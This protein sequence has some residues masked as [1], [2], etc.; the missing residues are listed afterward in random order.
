[1]VMAFAIA[2]PLSILALTGTWRGELSL[3][4]NKL[5]LVFH[6]SEEA[7]GQSR[8][9]IDSPMQ[10]ATGIP[11]TVNYCDADSVSL[12]VK[13]IG[14]SFAAKILGSEIKGTFSQRGYSFPLT[15]TPEQ[16]IYERRPQTPRPP[17]PYTTTDTTFVSTDGTVLSGTI[18][19]PEERE[20]FTPAVVLVTG[21][22]PQN[23]DE[24]LFE[25]RPFA[26]IAD[27]LA[28]N[29]IASLR[30][31]DRGV[32]ESKGDFAK[33]GLDTFEADAEAA[34]NFLRGM[35]GKGKTGIIGHSEG[36]TIALKLA[37]EGK[38]DFAVSLAGAFAKG[39]DLILAQNIRAIEKLNVSPKQKEDVTTLISEVFDDIIEGKN[40]SE[41]KIDD[42]ITAGN[43]DIPPLFLTSL[44]R[45]LN[46]TQGTYF[47][48]LVSLDPS[49]WLGAVTVPVLA[50][51]GMCDT[52][53]DCAANLGA[54]KRYLP[55][56]ETKQYDGLNHL[57]QHA[58][59][60][61]VSEYAGI[62]ETI[63]AEVLN[64]I[65]AFIKSTSQLPAN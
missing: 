62:K 26:V 17:Y 24:E 39:K 46:A 3:G 32:G 40:Y 53:V 29:G 58:V 41:I 18:T 42:Y 63:S 38:V 44:R 13:S 23:R 6:F 25:H 49:E 64:D 48:Q 35:G 61:E 56:A 11:A 51:N 9:T 10:G 33:A 59:T 7:D 45:N 27:Y 30:Y 14:A 5:P 60:G 47:R 1:M 2:S 8:C 55:S 22:G 19:M 54:L 15:L 37:S 21:S 12:E 65:A 50:V 36:G 57:F 16:S 20:E 34:V 4:V 43:L 28:R 52:Q 31:D